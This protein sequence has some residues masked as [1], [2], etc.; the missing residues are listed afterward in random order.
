MEEK[1]NFYIF[2]DIDGVLWDWK[3]R[4]QAIENGKIKSKYDIIE[5]NSESVSVLNYLVERLSENYSPRLV[6]S[7]TWRQDLKRAKSVLEENG[8]KLEHE[9]LST[10]IFSQ[11]QKR[12]EEILRFLKEN[13]KG[14]FVIID[15]ESFD[16]IKHFSADKIIKTSISDSSLTKKDIL[17]W[18]D[19]NNSLFL[20]QENLER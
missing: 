6:L 19:K 14:D 4:R 16:Y 15:D 17:D 2:F 18:I 1:E 10:P 9:L 20:D 7:S 13:P 11:P 12:G 3:W 5:F 8:L